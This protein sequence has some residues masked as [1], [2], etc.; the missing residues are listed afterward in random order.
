MKQSKVMSFIETGLSTL[1]GLAVALATQIIVFPLFGWNPTISTNLAITAIF[2]V[3][4][5]VRQY[6]VRRLFEKLHIRHPLSPGM[7]AV[8]AERNRQKDSEGWSHEHDDAHERG[9]LALAGAAYLISFAGFPELARKV[10]PWSHEFWKP[11]EIRP[12]RDLIRGDALGLAELEKFDRTKKKSTAA[13]SLVTDDT[14]NTR[15]P[16]LD[17]N[18]VQS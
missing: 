17:S 6:L 10:W 4:S 9:E 13:L 14:G 3:V 5:I 18:L 7:R 16:R 2:T 8:A 1:I 12:R 15:S 11:D